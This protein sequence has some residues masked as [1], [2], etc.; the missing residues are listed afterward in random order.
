MNNEYGTLSHAELIKKIQD[1]ELGAIGLTNYFNFTDDDFV[2][3][4]ALERAGVTVF[5]NLEIRLSYQNKEDDCCDIHIIFDPTVTKT[6]MDN[7]LTQLKVNVE[8][9]DMLAKNLSSDNDFTKATV[10]FDKLREVLQ[11]ESLGLRDKHIIGFLSRGKGNGRT[12]SNYEKIAKHSHFLIHSTDRAENID[13]DRTFWLEHNKP[14]LQ[15]SDAHNLSKIGPKYSWVKADLTFDGLKQILYE[16]SERILIQERNPSDSKTGRLTIDYV[17]YTNPNG[18][19]NEVRLNC[20]LNSIIGSRGSGKSTLLKNIAKSID[21]EEF[22][23]RDRKLPYDLIDFEVIWLDGQLNDGKPE[24]PKSIFYIPQNYLSAL[25]YDD[26]ERSGE[27]DAFLTQLLKKNERFANAIQSFDSFVSKNKIRIEELIQKLLD[28]RDTIRE[29]TTLLKKQGSKAEIEQE[30]KQKKQQLKKYKGSGISESD[31]KQYSNA[32]TVVS[33]GKKSINTLEQDKDILVSLTKS[34]ANIFISDQEFSLLSQ[35]RQ[36]LIQQELKKRSK[37]S[38]KQ[39]IDKELLNID[40]QIKKYRKVVLDNEKITKQL[41]EQIKKSKA[42]DD[43]TKEIASLDK[44]LENIKLLTEQLTKAKAEQI[45]TIDLLVAA[46]EEFENQQSIVYKTI[47]FDEKFSFLKVQIIARYDTL[48]LKSFVERYIN[49]RDTSQ[50]VKKESDVAELFGDTPK[51]PRSDTIRKIIAGLLDNQV[52]PKV[53]ARDISV[54]LSQ[55]L[56]NR[57]EID[58]L[59]SVKTKNG[60]THFKDMTGGQKAIALLELIFRFDD[61]KYPIL[62]DQP[63]DDLD[64][65]GVANDLVDFILA[66]KQDRQIIIVSHN[67]SLVIC[68]D[69][70]NIIVSNVKTESGKRLSFKYATGSIENSDRRKDIINVL[71]GGE[72]ALRKRMKKL[73][74]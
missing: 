73:F 30:I 55:L 67:A 69:T 71:E 31:I 22:K 14:L 53:E 17:K 64:V 39:L 26:G 12:S 29:N 43:L 21:P 28:N 15:S 59:N 74:V 63:E 72:P 24:S 2:L 40:D 23:V 57:F 56:K 54:V 38:L 36:E 49:T 8:G 65:S 35:D 68:A 20:D 52:I 61:E 41:G 10:E 3:K 46:Y 11:E 6:D 70:E 33:N 62:I 50:A 42:L 19:K 16:P 13:E 44:S 5:M 60:V 4:A 66:E 9:T 48:D 1:S 18:D 7:F 47:K 34:G 37:I 25:A 45:N 32:Q 51:K 27:R 58:Y